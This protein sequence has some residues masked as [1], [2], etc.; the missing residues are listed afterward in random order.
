MYKT[1]AI[2]LLLASG[3]A[4]GDVTMK[5]SDGTAFYLS[6]KHAAMGDATAQVVFERGS[7]TFIMINHDE[8]TWMEVSEDFGNDVRSAIDQQMQEM[9]AQLPPEQR[10]MVKR[11]MQNMPQ[12]MGGMG[13][14]PPKLTVEK[15]GKTDTVAGYKCAEATVRYGRLHEDQVCIATMDELG[16]KKSDFAALASAMA[17][18][19]RMAGMGRDGQESAPD[20]DEMGG[21]PIRSSSG[22]GQGGH[23]LV[24]LTRDKVDAARFEVPQGYRKVSMEDLMR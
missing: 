24:A 18:M 8:R 22:R 1:I 3:A 16:L 20:L 10:E 11:Q 15:T 13:M 7:D 6:D 4:A 2:A 21:I 5:Y 23:E 14:E 9:L 19:S 12:M 17:S